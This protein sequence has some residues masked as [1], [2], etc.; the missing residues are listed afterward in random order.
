M[1]GY[2]YT[3]TGKN[4]YVG[5]AEGI[6][7]MVQ[8]FAAIPAGIAA[9]VK[10]GRS[11]VLKVS[12]CFGVLATVV[13]SVGLLIGSPF[14]K[15]RRFAFVTVGMVR[16]IYQGLWATAIPTIYSDSVPTGKRS[17][18]TT[19]RYI[20]R[21]I[22]A[23]IGPGSAI[24][25]YLIFGDNWGLDTKKSVFVIGICVSSLGSLCLFFFQDVQSNDT[26]DSLVDTVSRTKEQQKF[27][28]GQR[29]CGRCCART[30]CNRLPVPAWC[31]PYFLLL[32]DV[33]FGLAS[34]MTIKFFPLFF[35]NEVDLSPVSIC[36]VYIATYLLMA[37][38]TRIAQM[39][40]KRVGR[41]QTTL[42]FSFFGIWCLILMSEF[43]SWWTKPHII[44]PIYVLRTALMNCCSPLRKSI[45]MD[46]TT[47]EARGRWNSLD[48]ITRFGWSGTY[49]IS[50]S[51]RIHTDSSFPP[52]QDQ[53]SWEDISWT[54]KDTATHSESQQLCKLQL[55]RVPCGLFL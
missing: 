35:R 45:L 16:G 42:S 14:E 40:S 9:I 12:A 54:K 11:F 29:C 48:G 23:L 4:L 6:Q 19:Y 7:G 25:L 21:L 39:I 50:L 36:L 33:I 41:I 24:V 51:V 38:L 53:H 32:T 44:C 30:T 28:V 15:F 52:I 18:Y 17:Q 22:A 13:T 3:L 47:K 5:L 55:G 2:L 31:I 26:A 10:N 1:S 46:Y 37:F 27:S 20:A 43:D 49:R 8:C 34:G